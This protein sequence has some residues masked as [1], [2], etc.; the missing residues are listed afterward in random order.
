MKKLTISLVMLLALLISCS[1]KSELEIDDYQEVVLDYT[2]SDYYPTSNGEI[3]NHTYYTLSY[4]EEHEQAEW[5]FYLLTKE[6]VNG[7]EERTD[8]F[9]EDPLVSTGSAALAD[10][11]GSGYDRGH[12]CPAKAMSLNETSMSESFFMS[13]MTP[14]TAS[15]NRGRWKML[16]TQVRDWVDIY[17]TLYIVSGA[18]LKDSIESLGDNMVTVPSSFYKVIYDP[19]PTPRMIAFIMPNESMSEDL[20]YYAVNVDEV[21]ELTNI[22]F[23]SILPD[24]IEN[25]LEVNSD[26][27]LW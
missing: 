14:Q 8:D 3:V 26:Y 1:E 19:Y 6:M 7:T 11:V 20:D 27:S 9:R 25:S 16:E 18:I 15:C 24:E 17:D 13:N 22:D 5:V 12:L 10:Y 23:Y 4:L 2:F 21:E